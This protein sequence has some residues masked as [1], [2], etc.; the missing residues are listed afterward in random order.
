MAKCIYCDDSGRRFDGSLCVC[1]AAKKLLQSTPIILDIPEQYQHVM[2]DA[3]F[4]PRKLHGSYGVTLNKIIA[5]VTENK[6]ISRNLLICAP[7]N[8]GK[9]IFAYTIIKIL[10][11]A[12]A[13]V[14][15]IYDLNEVRMMMSDRYGLGNEEY[16]KFLADKTAIVKIPMD[17]PVK[18]VEIMTSIIDL[19]LRNSG[20]TIFLYD[21]AKEDLIS[22][23]KYDRLSDILGDGSYHT[24]E[25]ISYT[26]TKKEDNEYD[27]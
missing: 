20:N 5:E 2:F 15:K 23:D 14:P 7:P 24:V 3:S 18:F 17:V 22:Q 19:R 1:E 11:S 21:A 25:C 8:S 6:R 12:N 13:S 16:L 10:Y 27:L 9:S 4:L 26:K